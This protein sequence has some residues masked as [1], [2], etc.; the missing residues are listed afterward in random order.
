MSVLI[1]GSC[2]NPQLIDTSPEFAIPLINSSLSIEDVLDH[3]NTGDIVQV[4]GNNFITLTYSE[5]VLS[6]DTVSLVKVPAF[7]I[8]QLLT[9][10]TV[11]TSFPTNF[12]VDRITVKNSKLYVSFEANALTAFTVNLTISSIKQGN[13]QL[14]HTMN[15]SNPSGTI[16]FMFQDSVDISGYDITFQNGTFSSQYTAKDNATNLPVVLSNFILNFPKI[17]YTYIEG[18]FGKR[19]FSLPVEQLSLGLFEQWKSGQVTFTDPKFRFKFENSY[20]FPLYVDFDT[21]QAIT[22]DAGN[23]DISI[24]GF[25]DGIDLNYPA[26]NEVGQVK[27]SNVSFDKNNSNIINVLQ[28]VPYGLK[29]QFSGAANRLGDS[30]STGFATDASKITM[31]VIAEITDGRFDSRFQIN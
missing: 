13:T 20:G 2:K 23:I 24:T 9:T 4:D 3:A 6:I 25:D 26:L 14:S 11:P 5:K 19:N 28:Q 17:D 10:Q 30:T 21:L 16:P 1:L 8:P 15:V 29:Y 12:R 31:T 18:Y 7:S 22:R 27:T